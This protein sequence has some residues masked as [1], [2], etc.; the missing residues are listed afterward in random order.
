MRIAITAPPGVHV[1]PAPGLHAAGNTHRRRR[2][3]GAPRERGA[4]LD[5]IRHPACHFEA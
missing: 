5:A 1:P 4:D 3:V 2:F